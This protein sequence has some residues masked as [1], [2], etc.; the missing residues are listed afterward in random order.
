MIDA[1]LFQ[2]TIIV[3]ADSKW[4]SSILTLSIFV[5]GRSIKFTTGSLSITSK[6]QARQKIF[7]ILLVFVQICDNL[8]T[9]LEHEYFAVQA[10]QNTF[11]E[12][13]RSY[14]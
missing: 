5:L 7:H 14:F 8:S 9:E 11:V 12:I 10:S 2:G 3:N 6:Y 1:G 4:E 13:V